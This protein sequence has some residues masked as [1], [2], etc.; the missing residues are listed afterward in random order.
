M[1]LGGPSPAP[2]VGTQLLG[3]SGSDMAGFGSSSCSQCGR[4]ETSNNPLEEAGALREVTR[5][6]R[7]RSSGFP[8]GE[9]PPQ[10]EVRPELR[11]RV[12]S[13]QL[14]EVSEAAQTEGTPPGKCREATAPRACVG[15]DARSQRSRRGVGVG[16]WRATTCR[17]RE[18]EDTGPAPNLCTV[19]G[20]CQW[21]EQTPN[22]SCTEL[23]PRQRTA[24]ARTLYLPHFPVC[25]QLRTYDSV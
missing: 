20:F 13:R 4:K 19:Y 18:S 22:P 2:A 12:G 15:G 11:R 14:K 9:R 5:G 17:L 21:D 25:R 16:C 3:G 7:D 1:R 10:A 6:S 23:P 24:L 8:T